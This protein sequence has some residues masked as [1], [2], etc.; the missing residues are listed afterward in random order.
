M[1]NW[2]SIYHQALLVR[3]VSMAVI[4]VVLGPV[5]W[6]LLHTGFRLTKRFVRR[7]GQNTRLRQGHLS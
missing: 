1:S 4:F 7:I 3:L 6:M 5:L 2:H